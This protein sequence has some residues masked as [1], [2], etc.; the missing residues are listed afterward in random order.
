LP[1]LTTHQTNTTGCDGINLRLRSETLALILHVLYPVIVSFAVWIF[2]AFAASICVIRY[3]GRGQHP[4]FKDRLRFALVPA[5]VMTA[6]QCGLMVLRAQPQVGVPYDVKMTGER[7]D[8]ETSP[9]W[10][11]AA[12]C[13]FLAVG[14]GL[15]IVGVLGVVLDA[16]KWKQ[17]MKDKGKFGK[18][19]MPPL[20]P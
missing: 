11:L 20:C 19:N 1:P 4:S 17:D 15:T 14:V 8:Y 13:W 5:I 16:V 2:F 7:E 18:V 3:N 9:L 10:R 12:G 6:I